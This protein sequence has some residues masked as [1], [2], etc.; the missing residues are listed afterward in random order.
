MATFAPTKFLGGRAATSSDEYTGAQQAAMYYMRKRRRE[1]ANASPSQF[2]AKNSLLGFVVNGI[3]LSVLP[4]DLHSTH[5]LG[6]AVT[7]PAHLTIS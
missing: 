2:I 7:T 4:I 5:G 3:V 1:R 6:V